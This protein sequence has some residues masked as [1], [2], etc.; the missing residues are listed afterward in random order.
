MK[1]QSNILSIGETVFWLIGNKFCEGVVRDDL[2]K[3][4]V[5][6]LVVRINEV[7]A[8]Q[9][10]AVKRDLIIRKQKG[11]TMEDVKRK[12]T[13][14]KFKAYS[15]NQIIT[16]IEKGNY[17]DIEIDVFKEILKKRGKTDAEI[18]A[19]VN[20]TD[21]VEVP[22][23]EAEKVEEKA[24]KVEEK[25]EE[26]QPEAE[27]KVVHKN[28][29]GGR[30]VVEMQPEDDAEVEKQIAEKEASKNSKPKVE[31]EGEE[32]VGKKGANNNIFGY[33]LGSKIDNIDQVLIAAKAPLT[34]DEIKKQL[35][36]E[37]K[38]DRIKRHLRRLVKEKC[39]VEITDDNKYKVK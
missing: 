32:N 13:F 19:I 3:E 23:N 26:E 38:D 18:E 22:K 15:A 30:K 37:I 12:L 31:T 20:K 4:T 33:R 5:H 7:K 36:V 24:E 1:K 39:V 2:G 11:E 27:M 21:K 29:E 6:V 8:N 14:N 9:K 34:Y 17:T 35:T 28:V 16:K 25:T 10:T